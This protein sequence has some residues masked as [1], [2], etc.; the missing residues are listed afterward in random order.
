MRFHLNEWIVRRIHLEAH[1]S[2]ETERNENC[3]MFP[4]NP[5]KKKREKK[6][7]NQIIYNQEIYCGGFKR[8]QEICY[9]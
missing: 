8:E 4:G 2:H 5:I 7:T 6:K 1:V 9:S 3:V